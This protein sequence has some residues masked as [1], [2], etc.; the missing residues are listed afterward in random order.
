[1]WKFI[2]SFLSS[3]IKSGIEYFNKKQELKTA[4]ITQ[5]IKLAE[6]D[7]TYNSE[8]ELR[9]LLNAGWKDDILFYGVI[10]IFIWAGVDPQAANNYFINLQVLP[11]WFITTFVWLIASV[12]GVRKFGE[13]APSIIKSIKGAVKHPSVSSSY[14]ESIK[15]VSKEINKVIKKF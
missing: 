15:E 1:M 14:A 13:Y 11:E 9:S 12:I 2:L 5:K 10:G 8:W 7:M 6:S 3:P 4:V